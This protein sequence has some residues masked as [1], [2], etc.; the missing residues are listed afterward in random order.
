LSGRLVVLVSG[1]GSNLQALI[2]AIDS[3][4]LKAE[5]VAVISNRPGVYALSRAEAAGIPTV[6]APHPTGNKSPDARAAY[7]KEL[8]YT[9]ASYRPDLVVLSGWDR[10]LSPHFVGHHLTINLHPAKPG[11]FRGLGAIERAFDAWKQGRITEGGVMVHYVPDEGVDDGPVIDWEPIAFVESD[12][13][14]T[15]SDR[16]HTVEHRLLVAS[17]RTALERITDRR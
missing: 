10:V 11:A 5:I 7:D 2:D 1:N 9:A 15:Y 3:G 4:S 14:A 16:V 6:V 12:T 17:V 8:A 13:L